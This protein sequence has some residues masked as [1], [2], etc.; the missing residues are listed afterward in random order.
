MDPK[1]HLTFD[2]MIRR[3]GKSYSSEVISEAGEPISEFVLPFS[4]KYLDDL[5]RQIG[6]AIENPRMDCG[7]EV[8]S[9]GGQLFEA[10]F[11]GEVRSCLGA[12]INKAKAAKVRVMIRLRLDAVPELASLPWEYLYNRGSQW[13]LA[14]SEQTPIIRYLPSPDPPLP[15]LI[16]PP[17][18]ILVMVSRPHDLEPLDSREETSRISQALKD[19]MSRKKVALT[20]LPNATPEALQDELLKNKYHVFHFI[21]HGCFDN[22]SGKGAIIMEDGQGGSQAVTGDKLSVMLDH[23]HLRLTV[24]N[25][26]EG[27]GSGRFDPFGGVA[28]TMIRRGLPAAVAMQF[29]IRDQSAVTFSRKFYS[30]LAEGYAIDACL[31]YARRAFYVQGNSV[32]WGTPVLFMRSPDGVIFEIERTLEE[33]RFE[34]TRSALEKDAQIALSGRDYDTAIEKLMALRDLRASYGMPLPEMPLK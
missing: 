30:A 11:G 27:A 18:N 17:L 33:Q 2:L 8:K 29:M 3:S 6:R 24:L 20:F 19:L 26:C 4:E 5:K 10:A 14:L 13:F 1:R 25:S 21:G 7:E 31:A 22:S 32:E 34:A 16:S 28:Q 23:F 9:F 15:L 12:C